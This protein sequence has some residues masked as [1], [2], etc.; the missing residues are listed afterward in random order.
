MP[1]NSFELLDRQPRARPDAPRLR[2]LIRFL[3]VDIIVILLLKALLGLGLFSGPDQYVTAV[4][5]SKLVLAGYLVWLVSRREDGW[6][7]VGANVF[8]RWWAW[9]LGP[10]IY[11]ASIPGFVWINKQNVL[12]LTRFF[13][14]FGMEYRPRPQEVLGLV[15]A[16]SL[17][18]WTRLLLVFFIVLAGPVMEEL[19]FRG[20][21]MAA[22]AR[23]GGRAGLAGV[24]WTSLLFGLYHFDIN[25]FL[26][27]SLF[28]I[29]MAIFR[30]ASG[31]VWCPV[32]VHCFHNGF[33]LYT[34]ARQLGVNVIPWP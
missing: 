21:G 19:A 26:P 5:L 10:V 9:L 11:Y 31:S 1:V 34:T 22:F 3:A 33:I 27:L 32:L 13:S 15:F 4:L 29:L 14:L 20:L 24:I 18:Q 17:E 8:G 2:D 25:T 12:F 6:G 30:L 16:D 28:G 23:E 7:R